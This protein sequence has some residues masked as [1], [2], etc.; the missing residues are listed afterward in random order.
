MSVAFTT[1]VD[2]AVRAGR[3]VNRKPLRDSH[4]QQ[5]KRNTSIGKALR[6]RSTLSTSHTD[7]NSVLILC[8]GPESIFEI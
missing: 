6:Q 1:R 8:T 2:S 5:G 7:E 3:Q 4:S